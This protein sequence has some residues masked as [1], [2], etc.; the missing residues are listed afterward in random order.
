MASG[1]ITLPA[2][3][4]LLG[5]A[6][7]RAFVIFIS[8]WRLLAIV[9][10]IA[11]LAGFANFGLGFLVL[12]CFIVYWFFASLANVVRIANPSTR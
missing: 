7:D 9:A 3:G 2:V 8:R 12:L 6:F 10:V 5:A 11:M 4:P 1:V